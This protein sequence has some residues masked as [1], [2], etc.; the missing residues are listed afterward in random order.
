MLWF[1][2]FWLF[3]VRARLALGRWPQPSSPNDPVEIGWIH[4]YGIQLGTAW[5]FAAVVT[6][7]LASVLYWR[8]LKA[9]RVRPGLAVT[10][11]AGSLAAIR[12]AAEYRSVQYWFHWLAD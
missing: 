5:I 3:V 11:G 8:E 4:Y 9:A 1:G 10:V 7:V 12:F 2:A 6:L